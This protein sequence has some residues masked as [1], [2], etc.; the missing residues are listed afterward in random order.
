M[1]LQ[2][3]EDTKGVECKKDVSVLDESPKAYKPIE[4]V[5][6]AQENLVEIVYTLKQVLCVKG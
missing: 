1:A 3:A 5:M 6:K 2:H 4:S